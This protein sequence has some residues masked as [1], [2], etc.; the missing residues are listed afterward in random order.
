[1]CLTLARGVLATANRARQVEHVVY[2]LFVLDN[3]W[4][5]CGVPIPSEQRLPSFA[6]ACSSH[7]R[8]RGFIAF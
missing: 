3:Q 2:L 7:D 6:K 4:V 8:F 1:M 5:G